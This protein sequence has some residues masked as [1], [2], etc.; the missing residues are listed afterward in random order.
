MP[1]VRN[2]LISLEKLAGRPSIQGK[3]GDFETTDS[4]RLPWKNT[5]LTPGITTVST[6]AAVYTVERCQ[7]WTFAAKVYKH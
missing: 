4:E 7:V 3:R 6:G 5:L 2:G 1:D